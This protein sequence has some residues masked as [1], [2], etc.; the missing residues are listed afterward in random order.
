MLTKDR[1]WR[2]AHELGTSATVRRLSWEAPTFVVDGRERRLF[3]HRYNETWRNERAVEVPLVVEA[4][5]AHPVL[6][7]GNVLGHYGHC[8]HTVVDKYE[9]APGVLNVDVLD[10]APHE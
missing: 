10:F 5:D 2:L 7:V 9:R 6:E 1:V 4:L 3:V 8:G